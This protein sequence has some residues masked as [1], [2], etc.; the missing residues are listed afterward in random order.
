MKKIIVGEL[1]P[2]NVFDSTRINGVQY[3]FR[4]SRIQTKKLGLGQRIYVHVRD[5]RWVFPT[6]VLCIHKNLLYV[7]I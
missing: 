7:Y 2:L 6:S 3:D 5:P 4:I 1:C